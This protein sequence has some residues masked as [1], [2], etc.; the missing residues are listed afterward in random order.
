MS[1]KYSKQK[2]TEV[3]RFFN[4][5]KLLNKNCD[6]VTNLCKDLSNLVLHSKTNS[7]WS[8]HCSAWKL[9]NEFAVSTNIKSDWPLDIK[10]ARN[11]T[12]WALQ[13]KKLKPNTVKSYLSSVKLAHSLENLKCDDLLKDD[14]IKM[15][16]KGAENLNMLSEKP[17]VVRVPMTMSLLQILGHRIAETNWKTYSKQTI[18]TVL[19]TSFFSSCRMG[20]LVSESENSYDKKTTVLWKHVNIFDSHTCIFVPFTKT[21]GLQGHVLEIFDFPIKNCCPHSAI[22]KLQEL[23]K[24]GGIYS[25]ESP[26]FSMQSGKLVTK[27]KLNQILGEFFSDLCDKNFE[28]ITCH[29]FRAAI[30]SLLSS[31]PDKNFVSDILDWGEWNSPAYGLYTK[32]DHS[33]RKILFEKISSLLCDST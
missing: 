19:L 7:T 27:A 24:K 33:R 6:D 5:E 9:Y 32:F 15:A 28:K 12:V 20:E 30:P 8:K 11:F 25:K 26:V 17:I 31:H 13:T 29:S 2:L 18:W 23:A 4:P 14:I 3:T 22:K 16:L 1:Q 10:S 21:K